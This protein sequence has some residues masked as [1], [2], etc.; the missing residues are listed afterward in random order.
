M[1]KTQL[2]YAVQWLE[3]RYESLQ[4][5]S[6]EKLPFESVQVNS[7]N[8]GVQYA[9]K[10]YQEEIKKIRQMLDG[11]LVEDVNL[12]GGEKHVS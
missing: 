5:A 8:S 9:N 6:N 10:W 3:Q 2:E 4:A 12:D 11:Y 7:F 1:T